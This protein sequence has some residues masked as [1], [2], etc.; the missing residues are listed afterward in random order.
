MA[1]I[2]LKDAKQMSVNPNNFG[3]DSDPSLPLGTPEKSQLPVASCYS[4]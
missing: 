1:G 4:S 2:E 3:D